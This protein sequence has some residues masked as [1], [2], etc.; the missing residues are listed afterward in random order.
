[1]D[2]PLEESFEDEAPP[3]ALVNS[4]SALPPPPPPLPLLDQPG[5]YNT[6]TPPPPPHPLE[7]GF[8]STP[9]QMSLSGPMNGAPLSEPHPVEAYD[10][11][12]EVEIIMRGSMENASDKDGGSQTLASPPVAPAKVWFL[13][14]PRVLC[15][16]QLFKLN[17]LTPC[18][19][20]RMD[21]SAVTWYAIGKMRLRTTSEWS[22]NRHLRK[23]VMRVSF[24]GLFVF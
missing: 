12:R 24:Y 5:T 19:L 8:W 21:V 18:A 16:V 6:E 14:S 13:L 23:L 17:N 3:A 9:A 15:T 11:D 2:D 4:V 22:I 20:N 10:S 7:Q 1:M